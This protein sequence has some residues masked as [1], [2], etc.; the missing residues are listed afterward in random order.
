M[1]KRKQFKNRAVNAMVLANISLQKKAL[2]VSEKLTFM[3]TVW[4]VMVPVFL[5]K[6]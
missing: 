2:R 5:K 3:P 1:I 4:Y 6:R